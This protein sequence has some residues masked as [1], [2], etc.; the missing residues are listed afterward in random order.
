MNPAEIRDEQYRRL[1]GR[2]NGLRS[3]I[4]ESLLKGGQA[5]TMA[6]AA[7]SG[8]SAFSVRPRVTELVAL[9]LVE[10]VDR[11]ARE[12]VY[13]AVPLETAVARAAGIAARTYAQ[14]QMDLL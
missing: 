12:G 4:Y 1:Q 13:R 7:R 14:T 2:L 3:S 9:G 8:I 11:T 10:C 5:T 6:L